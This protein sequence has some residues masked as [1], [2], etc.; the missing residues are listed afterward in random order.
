M[1]SITARPGTSLS[2]RGDAAPIVP[3]RLLR[4]GHPANRRREITTAYLLLI[5]AFAFVFGVLAYPLAWSIGLSLTDASVVRTTTRFVG[6]ANY[7][8]FLGDPAFW[9]ATVNTLGYLVLTSVFKMAVGVAIALA[10]ARPFPGRALVFLAAF[11][12]W[13]YPA[14][15]GAVG[16]YWFITPPLRSDY[17]MMVT[18]LQGV[19]DA[20]L[21]PGTWGFLSLI[22]FN[23][24]RGGSFVGV[25]LLAALNGIPQDLFDYAAL[26]VKSGWRRFWLVAVPLLRPFLALATFLSLVSAVAD[27]GNVWE[28]SG[29]RDVYPIVWT[30]SF[31]LALVTGSWG[32]AAALSLILLPVLFAIL[33][34]CYRLFDPL[35]DDAA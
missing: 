30:Q 5:P 2:P 17:S 27:L 22:L 14:G 21:G 33:F 15:L 18:H 25:F 19:F 23:I 24:W 28:L 35:E 6:L 12:P 13:A 29:F 20:W 16:W 7:A 31:M 32:R 11:L 34:V 8:A 3:A 10:L 26:E 9:R 4:G 1:L